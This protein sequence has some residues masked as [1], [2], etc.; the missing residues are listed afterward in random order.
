MIERTFVQI[1]GIP[2][3]GKTVLVEHL[4]RAFD[5]QVS[6]ARCIRADHLRDPSGS[7]DPGPGTGSCRGDRG[8]LR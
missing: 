6:V 1:G 5:G 8:S 2:K 7:K 3:A 4:L